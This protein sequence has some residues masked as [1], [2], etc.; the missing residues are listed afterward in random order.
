MFTVQTLKKG[1]TLVELM[2][3]MAVIAI[4]ATM[5]F[6]GLSKAQ[7]V[8][9]DTTRQQI[10]SSIRAANEKYYGDNSKYYNVTN[11]FC[12]LVITALVGGNYLAASPTDPSA[13]TAICPLATSGNPTIGGATYTYLAAPAAP[14]NATSYQLTLAKEGGGTSVFNSPQ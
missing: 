10:M 9:R 13:G 6:F 2:I 12:G 11:T 8:A 14:A 1:F 4:L 7:A 5:A 3:V